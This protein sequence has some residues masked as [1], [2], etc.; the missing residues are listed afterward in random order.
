MDQGAGGGWA[1][2]RAP[3]AGTCLDLSRRHLLYPPRLSTLYRVTGEP[4]ADRTDHR[5]YRAR[6]LAPGR[7]AP[8]EGLSRVRHGP[9][10]EHREFPAPRAPARPDRAAPGRPA[11][12]DVAVPGLGEVAARRGVQPR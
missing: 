11:R 6:R 3:P 1:T 9:P 10:L 2:P 5:N 7:A 12:P 8:P 4:H